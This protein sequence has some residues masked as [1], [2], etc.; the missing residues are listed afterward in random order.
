MNL[1]PLLLLH[2]RM[3]EW[4]NF[5]NEVQIR[6]IL[7]HINCQLYLPCTSASAKTLIHYLH[8]YHLP[9]TCD[10][11]ISRSLF[12][13]LPTFLIGNCKMINHCKSRTESES[14]HAF[15]ESSAISLN[16]KAQQKISW[17]DRQMITRRSKRA[18][19]GSFAGLVGLRSEYNMNNLTSCLNAFLTFPRYF[20]REP[21]WGIP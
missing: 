15:G 19:P 9:D 17:M 5:M 20:T 3:N 1:R 18:K 14:R 8:L 4:V 6:S 10:P 16:L 11:D 7:F 21:F 2:K 13:F 12:L